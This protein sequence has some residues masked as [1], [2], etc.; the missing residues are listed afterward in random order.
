MSGV[1]QLRI[2]IDAGAAISQP[3]LPA[4]CAPRGVAVA[5]PKKCD[6]IKMD[7]GYDHED[8]CCCD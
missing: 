1:H 3:R 6:R 5:D 8:V 2:L 7:K 4:S